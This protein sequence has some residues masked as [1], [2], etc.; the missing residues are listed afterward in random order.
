MS[1]DD[2]SSTPLAPVSTSASQSKF[3]SSK[4]MAIPPI[5]LDDIGLLTGHEIY[6]DWVDQMAAVF[7]AMQT[8]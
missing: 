3:K 7:D 1:S 6:V 5:K 4:E 8:R 2:E